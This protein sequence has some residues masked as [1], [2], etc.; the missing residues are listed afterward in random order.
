MVR[1]KQTDPISEQLLSTSD[2]DAS[3]LIRWVEYC[4]QRDAMLHRATSCAL[5]SWLLVFSVATLCTLMAWHF[6]AST[7]GVKE[8]IND[9]YGGPDV[10]SGNAPHLMS[11]LITICVL[12][13]LLPFAW[14]KNCVP[15]F[16][17]LRND[18]DWT[19]TG[20]AMGQLVPL[21][22]PYP[23]AFRFTASS[24]HC[25]S[26]RKWLEKA[27]QS[28]E[29]GQPAIA[30]SYSNHP[31]TTVLHTVMSHP[32][33]MAKSD[34]EAVAEH[35]ASTARRTL[36]L[37]LAAIPVAATLFAGLILWLSITSTFGDFYHTL[38]SSIQQFGY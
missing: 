32:D 30:T 21:G 25:E 3:A 10:S 7:I 27:A 18:I 29:S 33:S 38:S 14:R 6:Q 11:I 26:Q 5:A 16:R 19:T 20:N 36:S 17:R 34:W 13:V 2:P 24:L 9:G 23:T 37:L 31:D 35:Y 15:V 8:L 1:T 12:C 4:A 22:I 28:V